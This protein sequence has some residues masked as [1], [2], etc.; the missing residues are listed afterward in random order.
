MLAYFKAV[1][2]MYRRAAVA[3]NWGFHPRSNKKVIEFPFGGSGDEI[4]QLDIF[5]IRSNNKVIELGSWATR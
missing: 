5:N 4:P 2:R 1:W 3:P